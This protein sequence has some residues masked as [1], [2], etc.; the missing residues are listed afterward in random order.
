MAIKAKKSKTKKVAKRK[1]RTSHN[2][3]LKATMRRSGKRLPHGYETV[4]RKKK[5]R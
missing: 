2:P 5:R 1:T 4:A 3:S